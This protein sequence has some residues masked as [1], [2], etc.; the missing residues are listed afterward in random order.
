MA[1]PLSAQIFVG[2][3][4]GMFYVC[5]DPTGSIHHSNHSDL[6]YLKSSCIWL[7]SGILVRGS[8]SEP[9]VLSSP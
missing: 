6:K 8:C 2:V 3:L 7:V 5:C 1:L 4:A 9:P